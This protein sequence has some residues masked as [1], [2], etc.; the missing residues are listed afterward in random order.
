MK[1]Q[2]SFAHANLTDIGN[3]RKRNCM[4]AFYGKPKQRRKSILS[5]LSLSVTSNYAHQKIKRL[6]KCDVSDFIIKAN[7]MALAKEKHDPGQKNL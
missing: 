2:H 7:V 4:K 6:S 5:S 1:F 3:P